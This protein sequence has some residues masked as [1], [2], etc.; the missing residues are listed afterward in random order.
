MPPIYGYYINMK[1][2][3]RTCN[4]ETPDTKMREIKKVLCTE[5]TACVFT[6]NYTCHALRDKVSHL[7]V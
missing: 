5:G 2:G 7:T 1:Y 4:K 6:V 3:I